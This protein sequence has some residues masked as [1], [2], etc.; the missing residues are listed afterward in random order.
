MR[1]V[2]KWAQ[3]ARIMRGKRVWSTQRRMCYSDDPGEQYDWTTPDGQRHL[4]MCE[5]YA[6]Q[7]GWDPRAIEDV[8]DPRDW[9]SRSMIET[10][11]SELDDDD[12]DLL[13]ARYIDGATMA[14]LAADFE[15]NEV[16]IRQRLHRARRRL[17][18]V[19]L[20]LIAEDS[21]MEYAL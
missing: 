7:H 13:E 19:Y 2:T 11:M 4:A 20:D 5:A 17:R 14:E 1:G 6:R 15:C 16:A 8:D 21:E 10:A 12:Q 9:A 3:T 18:R